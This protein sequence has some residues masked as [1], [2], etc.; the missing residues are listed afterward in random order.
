[1]SVKRLDLVSLKPFPN[2][3]IKN[4]WHSQLE[5]MRSMRPNN[6][7]CFFW[8]SYMLEGKKVKLAF[9]AA[10][11]NYC[12]NM[13]VSSIIVDVATCLAIGSMSTLKYLWTTIPD[14]GKASKP[15]PIPPKNYSNV[16][17]SLGNVQVISWQ[18]IGL[19]NSPWLSMFSKLDRVLTKGLWVALNLYK[20]FGPCWMSIGTTLK[21]LIV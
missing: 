7:I 21:L 4:P 8:I 1:M 17:P 14:C 19:I 20:T 15:V 6:S 2:L 18:S 16:I 11:V 12:G 13:A 5:M 10:V 9:H 3:A